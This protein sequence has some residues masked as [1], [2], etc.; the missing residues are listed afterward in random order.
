VSEEDG[1][2]SDNPLATLNLEH[3]VTAVLFIS[4]RM[5]THGG[6]KGR[7]LA[8]LSNRETH[9]L[10][11]RTAS[12]FEVWPDRFHD[13]LE[14]ERSRPRYKNSAAMNREFGLF[15]ESLFVHVRLSHTSLHFLRLGF[16]SYLERREEGHHIRRVKLNLKYLTR[17]AAEKRL[18]VE[19]KALR[20]FISEGKLKTV[21]RRGWNRDR[22]LV[23][24]ESVE[25]LKEELGQL[26]DSVGVAKYLGVTRNIV[27]ELA[28]TRCLKAASGPNI[29]GN[30]G[31]KFY[32]KDVENLMRSITR[33]PP[34]YDSR[35]E[36]HP[37]L[38]TALKRFG[39]PTWGVIRTV[40]AI[41]AG[42]LLPSSDSPEAKLHSLN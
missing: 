2:R 1:V 12:I 14:Y 15:Y 8:F 41:L 19:W 3:L 32:R 7:G 9:D 16:A 13:F 34:E 21:T 35:S 29:D 40:K 27:L 20:R 39:R 30:K 37:D 4:G 25:N 11:L 22:I 5:I 31:L 24:A 23:E 42:K 6:M 38:R 26:L 28:A 33:C 10:M 18:G 17:H 36:H